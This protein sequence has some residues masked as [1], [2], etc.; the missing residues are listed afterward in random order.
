M[1]KFNEYF[2]D[3]LFGDSGYY[4]KNNQVGAQGDFVTSVTTSSFFGATIANYFLSQIKSKKLGKDCAFVELGSN[5]GLAL[6]DAIR[7]I[8]SIEPDILP[9]ISFYGVEPLFNDKLENEL[10]NFNFGQK[11][12]KI[13]KNIAE[14]DTKEAFIF[15]NEVLDCLPCELLYKEKFAS[16]NAHKIEFNRDD[17]QLLEYAKKF[18]ILKGE[19]P[20]NIDSFAKQFEHLKCEILFFDYGQMYARNDFSIRVYKNHKTEPLFALQ[21]LDDY[22]KNSDLTYDVNF[23]IF[24][25]EFEKLSFKSSFKTQARALIDFGLDGI[26]KQMLESVDDKTAFAQ[27]ARVKM[28]I[29]PDGFGERFKLLHLSNSLN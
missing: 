8:A 2:N 19:V 1:Q 14:I 22:F 28:L 7:Y 25:Y 11:S 18:N 20:I 12:L 17:A 26:I 9:Y 10:K 13:V 23:E 21:N 15:A 5:R 29:A 27:L 6:K 3:W 4:S 24:K 16:V